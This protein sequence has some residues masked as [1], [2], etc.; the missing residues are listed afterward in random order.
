[1]DLRVKHV[2]G[3]PISAYNTQNK[4]PRSV[5][6]TMLP[7]P[8][9]K[10]IFV[11]VKTKEDCSSFQMGKHFVITLASGHLAVHCQKTLHHF[12]NQS[13]ATL[14]PTELY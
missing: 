13:G 11:E 2:P 14:K 6:G 1:M 10:L 5:F 3:S 8:S 12:F 9:K 7:K 4:R